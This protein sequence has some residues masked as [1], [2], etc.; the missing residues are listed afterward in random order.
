MVIGYHVVFSVYGFWLPNDPRGS[1]SIYVAS[2]DLYRY[3]PATHVDT[4]RSVASQPHDRKRRLAAKSALKRPPVELD[5]FQAL[6]IAKGFG[7]SITHDGIV[8]WACSILPSH[9]H[10]VL[11]RHKSSV[12][13]M[14][15]RLKRS[16]TIMLL[17][18]ARHPFQTLRADNQSVPPSVWSRGHR[19]IFLDTP[20]DVV[21]DINYVEQNPIREG[22]RPQHWSFVTPYSGNAV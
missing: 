4:R 10:L 12:E 7:A 15:M 5:G 2:K 13:W 17:E 8:C 3:G 22:K 19:Q 9:V 18:E 20:A 6:A 14:I 11:A 21:R 1:G 16:G